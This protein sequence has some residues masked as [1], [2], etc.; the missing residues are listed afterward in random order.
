MI[1]FLRNV[2]STLNKS[3]IEIPFPRPIFSPLQPLVVIERH[4]LCDKPHLLIQ[5]LGGDIP[6]LCYNLHLNGVLSFCPIQS[7]LHQTGTNTH[8]AVFVMT[9][10]QLDVADTIPHY[11]SNQANRIAATIFPARHIHNI[12]KPIIGIFD[13]QSV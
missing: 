1:A 9:P 12:S 11:A 2:Y 4:F 6:C 7:G 13:P 8:L 10:R 5:P 3:C